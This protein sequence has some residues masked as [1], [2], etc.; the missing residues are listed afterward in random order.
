[1]PIPQ[2]T[3]RHA[4][5]WRSSTWLEVNSDRAKRSRRFK[6]DKRSSRSG[7]AAAGPASGVHTEDHIGGGSGKHPLARVR[8]TVAA[9]DPEAVDER[10]KRRGRDHASNNGTIHHLQGECTATVRCS[11]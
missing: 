7:D 11:W 9:M 4:E 6:F 8:L 2:L 3:R 10:R 1:M 5:E